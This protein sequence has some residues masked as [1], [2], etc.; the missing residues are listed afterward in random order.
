MPFIQREYGKF[1]K[2]RTYC[3]CGIYLGTLNVS[4]I[5]APFIIYIDWRH[6]VVTTFAFPLEGC[7]TECRPVSGAMMAGRSVLAPFRIP[8]R[9]LHAT[10]WLQIP[11]Q[12]PQDAQRKQAHPSGVMDR[13]LM[14]MISFSNFAG[15]IVVHNYPVK[16]DQDYP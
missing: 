7:Q 10:E 12:R 14:R 9:G 4:I 8:S 6:A 3:Q 13:I 16:Q 11:Q 1:C 2:Y 15:D 5:P